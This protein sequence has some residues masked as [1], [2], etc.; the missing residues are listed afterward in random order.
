MGWLF[1]QIVGYHG[2]MFLDKFRTGHIVNGKDTGIENMKQVWADGIR[3]NGLKFADVKRGIAGCSTAKFPPSFPDFLTFCKPQVDPLRAYY[4]ALEGIQARNAGNVGK[5]SHPAIFWASASMTS[6]LLSQTYSQIKARW[7]NALQVQLDKGEWEGIPVPALALGHTNVP[8][9]PETV[10]R[11]MNMARSLSAS[12][13]ETDGHA[14]WKR[15]LVKHKDNP[16]SV[17]SLQLSE[18]RMAQKNS[19]VRFQP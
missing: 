19:R 16:R 10:E 4:E 6:E 3:S 14:W 9:N 12:R 17:T 1:Q 5:W 2:N 13:K 15:I 11:T 7:E 18:A 8:V